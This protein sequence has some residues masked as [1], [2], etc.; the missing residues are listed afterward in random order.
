MK[1]S[2]EI[3]HGAAVGAILDWLEDAHR[4]KQV[5]AIGHR[6]VHGGVD[7]MEPIII[8]DELSKSSGV[9][10]RS[11]PCTSPITFRG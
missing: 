7:F 8:D 1:A 9:L 10:S 5:F 3:D 2:R 4:N 11:R 6:V